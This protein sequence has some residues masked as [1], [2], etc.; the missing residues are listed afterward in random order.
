MSKVWKYVR[1]G[2]RSGIGAGALACLLLPIQPH[3]L[4]AWSGLVLLISVDVWGLVSLAK[5]AGRAMETIRSGQLPSLL[6]E[7]KRR[8]PAASAHGNSQNTHGDT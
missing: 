4:A 6:I 8:E 5:S 3:P 7:F 1:S 2:V